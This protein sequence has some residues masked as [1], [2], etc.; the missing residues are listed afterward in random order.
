M[1]EQREAS[2]K[3]VTTALV[4]ASEKE[5]QKTGGWTGAGGV[6]IVPLS[7]GGA[8]L[9]A[10]VEGRRESKKCAISFSVVIQM[11]AR[12]EML[13]ITGMRRAREREREIVLLSNS[14]S[15]GL[16]SICI[17]LFFLGNVIRNAE[18]SCH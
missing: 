11:H 4:R 7:T 18:P 15:N 3:I 6:E 14:N 17:P 5:T 2:E 12:E 1:L 16:I 10:R 8:N 9:L 13:K